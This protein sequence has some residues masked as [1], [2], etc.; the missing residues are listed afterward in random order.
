MPAGIRYAGIGD[1][2]GVGLAA[3]IAALTR[4]GWSAIEL[5]TV[6][7]TAVAD[8]D[9]AAF[10][11]VAAALARAGLGVVCIDSRIGN[12]ARPIT[13]SFAGDLAELRALIPRCHALHTRYIRVMSYPNDG[14]SEADW[15][16]AAIGRLRRLARVAA[17][18]GLVLLHENCA[19]WA[20]TSARRMLRLLAEVDSPALRL[21]F[22]VGNGPAHRYRAYE[23]LAEVLPYVAHVHVK[24]AVGEADAVA[25][26]LP[27]R[28]DCRVADCLRLLV[29]GGYTGTWSIEPHLSV[30]P[31]EGRAAVDRVE[32]FVDY[33]RCLERLV[34]D[35][36]SWTC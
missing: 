3:Q 18:S 26:T 24:D 13:T 16:R 5:R 11:A 29:A 25:Y 23:V 17:D 32:E 21:L 30:R 31:H 4:L 35:E 1:E 6:D 10:A 9:E 36:V 27:G 2:A 28:G 15:A 33:G 12:W 19:G 34:R 22:D 7:A 20:A 8:L 14:R